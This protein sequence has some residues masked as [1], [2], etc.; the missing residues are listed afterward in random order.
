M[1]RTRPPITMEQFALHYRTLVQRGYVRG[2]APDPPIRVGDVFEFLDLGDRW[3]LT[4]PVW[5]PVFIEPD[6]WYA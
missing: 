2:V 4:G 5:E 6:G 1:K 3:N